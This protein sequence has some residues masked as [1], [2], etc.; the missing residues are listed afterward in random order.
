MRRDSRMDALL[1]INFTSDEEGAHQDGNLNWP[2]RGATTDG[3]IKS[4]RGRRGQC[5]LSGRSGFTEVPDRT[6][7][8]S[9]GDVTSGDG[10][11]C[12]RGRGSC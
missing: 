10:V 3:N 9:D 6:A 12:A 5:K 11:R 4:I 2:F 1:S 7:L 8:V